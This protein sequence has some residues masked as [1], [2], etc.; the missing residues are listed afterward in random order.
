MAPYK[1]LRRHHTIV[2]RKSGQ[3]H[4]ILH[5]HCMPSND[6]FGHDKYVSSPKIWQIKNFVYGYHFQIFSY[7][8]VAYSLTGDYLVLMFQ[9]NKPHV[10]TACP[11]KQGQ[12]SCYYFAS[13]MHLALGNLPMPAAAHYR[14]L[15]PYPSRHTSL[16]YATFTTVSKV[17]KNCSIRDWSMLQVSPCLGWS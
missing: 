5:V 12:Q 4:Q 7:L 11:L 1:L 2:S 8:T 6:A 14:L 15:S 3:T 9:G 17:H 10:E 13:Y 16:Q